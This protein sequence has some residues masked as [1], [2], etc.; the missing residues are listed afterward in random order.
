M[1]MNTTYKL[2]ADI[3]NEKLIRKMDKKLHGTQFGFRA[4]R[5][6]MDVLYVL[7]YIYNK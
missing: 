7:N 2:Y 3:L 6:T 5:E 4:G 1:L